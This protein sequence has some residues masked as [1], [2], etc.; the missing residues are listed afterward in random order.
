MAVS[1]AA[2]RR[3]EL[4]DPVDDGRWEAFV[5]GAPGADVFHH[6]AWLLLLRR[7]YGHPLT[8]C[9]IVDAAGTI[10]AGAP[11]A[12][13]PDGL[14]GS[15]LVCLPFT[16]ECA[17]LPAPEEDPVLARELLDALDEL[18]R[19]L[20]VRV[21]LRGRVAP[22][23]SMHVA[24]RHYAHQIPLEPHVDAVVR[25]AGRRLASPNGPLRPSGAE[26]RV[27]RRTDARALAEFDRLSAS[28]QRRLGMPCHPRRF[29][30]G[31]AHLFDRG[32]GF[33]LLAR[34]GGCAVAGAVFLCFNGTLRY[35]CGA[36]EA[37]APPDQPHDLLLLEAVRW[38]CAA[39]M[40]R[41]SLGRTPF[42]CTGLREFKLSW[43]AEE[44]VLEFHE[45]GDGPPRAPAQASG[46]WAAPLIRHSPPI[47]SRVLAEALYRHAAC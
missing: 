13:V 25:R 31:L 30:L 44:R 32:L 18:R 24:A 41:L 19:A 17:P 4:L 45:I 21:A 23:R 2:G 12:L 28:A 11:L 16:D 35:E 10:H 34:D 26:L 36:A 3:V 7:T 6:R 14:R 9:C 38:G 8:A 27:E 29:I 20:G 42:G 15:R 39:G 37:G 5:G 43:G 47:V 33:V 22:H 40:R 46:S 1:G